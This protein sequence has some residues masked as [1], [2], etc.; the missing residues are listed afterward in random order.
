MDI[1]MGP[2]QPD[3]THYSNDLSK[4]GKRVKAKSPHEEEDWSERSDYECIE[5]FYTPSEPSE[6]SAE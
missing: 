1:R 4:R 3:S 6:Q 2:V 5:D